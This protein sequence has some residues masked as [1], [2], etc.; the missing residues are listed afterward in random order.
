MIKFLQT[1]RILD[2]KKQVSLT[3]LALIA[4]IINMAVRKDVAMNDMLVFVASI[5]GYQVKRFAQNP[6]ASTDATVEEINNSIAQLES[7]VTA[8]QIGNSLKS[9]R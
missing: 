6:N 7:K 3:N 9:K 8:L 2:D 4:A 1:L 5:V